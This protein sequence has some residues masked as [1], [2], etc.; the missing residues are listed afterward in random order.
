M[1]VI[2]SPFDCY[3][4]NRSIKTLDL[5]MRR[6]EHNAL[7]IAK[8]LTKH[9]LIKSVVYPG[10][11]DHP[12][13]KLIESQMHGNGGMISFYLNGDLNFTKHFLNRLKLIPIA[14][15]LGGVESLVEHPAT[16]TH[17]SI[18]ASI[19]EEIGITDNLVR[20]SVGLEDYLD[21]YQDIHSAL[22][23]SKL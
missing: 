23:G 8:L 7:A 17:S 10:L 14:E 4:V 9:P 19:R 21:I 20:L 22:N 5:R 11:P 16:M 1:G 13:K 3:L 12:Q 18:E 15:S 6:H 2:P